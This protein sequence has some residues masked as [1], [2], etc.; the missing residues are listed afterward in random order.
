[1]YARTSCG[2]RSGV[3]LVVTALPVKPGTAAFALS[4]SLSRFAPG[5]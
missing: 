3:L 5:V 1:M 2:A 4:A